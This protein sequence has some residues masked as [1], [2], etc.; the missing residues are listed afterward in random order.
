MF[1]PAWIVVS[2]ISGSLPFSIWLG[3]LAMSVDIRHYGDGNPGAA[4]VWRAAGPRWGMLAIM[5][6]FLKGAVPV[7][8]GNYLFG[9]EGLVLSAVAVA[10]ILG[11][12][13][14]PWLKLRGGKALAVSFGIWA[15]LTLWRI[16][17]L[18]GLLFGAWLFLLETEG[19][20]VTAGL[21]SL[22]VVLFSVGADGVL[23]TVWLGMFLI[24]VWKHRA[25]LAQRPRLRHLRGRR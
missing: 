18:M 14:S 4:N 17:T 21:L 7:S 9:L 10:P 2:F 22:L 19:W 13:F 15:G 6:D 12:A 1:S 23:L 24:L 3:R 5:L 20:A 16:P 11:H 8:L 25:D